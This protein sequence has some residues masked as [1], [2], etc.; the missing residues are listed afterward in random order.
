MKCP[1]CSNEDTNVIDSRPVEGGFTVRRRRECAKCQYRFSTLEE[2]ELL[3]LIVVKENGTRESYMRE[4]VEN[5]IVRSLT[6]RP[7]KQEDFHRL[8]N[9]IER[10]IQKK[11]AREIN[12][13]EIGKIIMKHLQTFDKVA[14]IRFASVYRD[15]K[16]A[17]AFE[18]ELKKINNSKE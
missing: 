11:N 16:D 10:S 4:K 1:I 14:Y 9:A 8:V 12:S 17:K 7:Y 3:G 5:G 6:K 15:F 18:A 13:K 2:V